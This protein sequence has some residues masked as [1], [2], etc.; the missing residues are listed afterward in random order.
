MT[1]EPRKLR[2]DEVIPPEGSGAIQVRRLLTDAALMFQDD[3]QTDAIVIFGE[4]GGSQEEDLADAMQRGRITKPVIATTRK[5]GPTWESIWFHHSYVKP[6]RENRSSVATN[7]AAPASFS[8][9]AVE[10][11]YGPACRPPAMKSATLRT[12]LRV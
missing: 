8:L 3:P 5:I 1:E 2:P 6:A 7:S 10:S 12:Y 11:T 4:I 9:L